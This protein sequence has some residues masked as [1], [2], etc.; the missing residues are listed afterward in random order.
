MKLLFL[1]ITILIF[2]SSANAVNI[3]DVEEQSWCFPSVPEAEITRIRC[4]GV[5]CLQNAD[6]IEMWNEQ[7]L[8][9]AQTIVFGGIYDF[10][11]MRLSVRDDCD[12]WAN[13]SFATNWVDVMCVSDGD[14]LQTRT[15][16]Q[17]IKPFCVETVE[18]PEQQNRYEVLCLFCEDAVEIGEWE[19]VG[20]NDG[21]PMMR[22]KLV[23]ETFDETVDKCIKVENAKFFTDETKS[24]GTVSYV[25]TFYG[26]VYVVIP[27]II[28]VAILLW[29]RKRIVKW[30]KTKTRK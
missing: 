30:I 15:S 3:V 4:E 16:F 10:E 5:G 9:A 12:C 20:C 26:G 28:L 6:L 8:F 11:G 29:K 21:H 25:S 19:E 23:G 18:I 17:T 7:K 2:A 22:R 14:M 27:V 13:S 24:C 1:A